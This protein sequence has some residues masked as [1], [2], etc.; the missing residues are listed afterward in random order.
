MKALLDEHSQPIS[1]SCI[2]QSDKSLEKQKASF[3]EFAR[4]EDAQKP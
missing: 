3:R 2:R 4:V 1:I